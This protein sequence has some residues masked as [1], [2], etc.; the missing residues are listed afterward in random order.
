MEN[1]PRILICD[2]DPLMTQRIKALLGPTK[3]QVQTISEPHQALNLIHTESPDL[4]ILDV[5]LPGMTGF[6]LI[7]AIDHNRTD[8]AFILIIGETSIESAIKAIRKGVSDYLR[9]PF[10]PDELIIRVEKVLR[11]RQIAHD[12]MC[13]EAEKEQLQGQLRQSQ[14]M[15]AIGTLAGGIAHD[16]NNILS[17]ILGNTEL[18][19]A[20]ETNK[21]TMRQ[22]LNQILTASLRAR[23][24]IQQ[25]LSFSRNEESTHKPLNL[26]RVLE[27]SLKLVRSS[28]PTNI[29][30]DRDICD[31]Q[32]T[33]IADATQIHQIMLNLCTNAAH[34][35][36]P[37]GGVLT[38][39][40]ES[41]VLESTAS[42]DHIHLAAGNYARLVVADTGQGIEKHIIDRIFDPYFTT[43][44]TGKGTGMGLSVVHGIVKASGGDIQAFSQPGKFT[45]F[46]IYLPLVEMGVES[47]P[48]LLSQHHMPGGKERILLVDD[49]IMLVEMM[50]KVLEQLGYTVSAFHD[51]SDALNAFIKAPRAYDI[52][53][54][55]MTMP[56][57]AGTG[58]AKAV[59]K[60][61]HELPIILCTGY[62]EQLCDENLDALGIK[63]LIMKPVGMQQLAETIRTVLTAAATERRVHPRY[64]APVGTLVISS[65]HPHDRF[66]LVDIGAG[67]LAYY[68]AM[69]TILPPQK[70]QLSIMRPN[71]EI[72]ITDMHCR[73][74]SDIPLPQPGQARRSV[75][76]E[77]LSL[78]Q[79]KRINQF[80]Q[81]HTTSSVN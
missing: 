47:G 58:L 54:T 35:M 56:G 42:T 7:D 68:H 60:V 13:I 80:I 70:D 1:R 61:R 49:E 34:A 64:I 52:L 81:N 51:S 74:V 30:I 63:A 41:V 10:E 57:M 19:L 40:L 76:F 17:I 69:E 2:D 27:D 33:I 3:Y 55:D 39:R 37:D 11:Q 44:A 21:Q 9:K 18:A 65:S 23:E 26:N 20:D 14:K 12:N 78:S 32:C 66:N 79:R 25:L 43:K 62:N 53:I 16:F 29:A 6:E 24:M 59:R 31:S 67:G 5:M 8:P 15:E 4:V 71:G 28:L 36:G 22:N 48:P 45:E 72:F 73:I 50:H 38:V 75:C 46:Q 77:N